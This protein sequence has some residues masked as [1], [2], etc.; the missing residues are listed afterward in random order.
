MFP[1]QLHLETKAKSTP[2]NY[3]VSMLDY[4]AA[5]YKRNQLCSFF[6]LKDALTSCLALVTVTNKDKVRLVGEDVQVAVCDTVR[7]MLVSCSA[8]A[9]SDL[10]SPSH[11]LKLTLSHLMFSCLTWAESPQYRANAKLSSQSLLGSL[12]H[13][14]DNAHASCSV[15]CCQ[16]SASSPSCH[17]S[18][19]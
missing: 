19:Q 12:C 1:D 14:P 2:H 8:Q 16:V 18:H 10:L 3:T 17:R 6:I 9:R 15:P 7:Q 4:I 11:N 5:L 13:N